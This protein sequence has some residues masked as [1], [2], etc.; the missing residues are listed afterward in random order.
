MFMKTRFQTMMLGAV[1][2]AVAPLRAEYLKIQLHVKG[3]DCQLCARGVGASIQRIAGVE[4]V[5]IGLNKGVL[6]IVLAPGNH[7]ALSDLRRRI[8][9]N[10]FRSTQATVNAIGRPSASG[11]Q[12]IGTDESWN[13]NEGDETLQPI[14][15]TFEVQE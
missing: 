4:S 14:E 2:L 1:L 9:E 10:G 15:L 11:F 3:L 6:D 7:V 13:V 5:V 8:R 12:I